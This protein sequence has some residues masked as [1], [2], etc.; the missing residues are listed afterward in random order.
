MNDK[1]FKLKR[2]PAP[3]EYRNSAGRL[4]SLL[5]M[6]Q[7]NQ[8]YYNQIAEWYGEKQDVSPQLKGK[9]YIEFMQ[10]VS[11]VY[12]EFLDDLTDASEIPEESKPVIRKGLSNLSETVYPANPT[13]TP[14]VLHG[15]ERGLLQVAASMLPREDD[16]PQD[17]VDA[18][19]KS[20][21]QLKETIENADVPK[22]VRIALLEVARL[23]RNALDQYNIYGARGFKAAF[24]RMLAELMEISLREG[25]NEVK[26]QKWWQQAV[27]HAKLVDSVAGKMLKYKPLLEPLGTLL[28][29]SGAG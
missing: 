11:D 1:Q 5:E 8:T 16:L 10:V 7:S 26:N 25:P 3:P 2:L 22:S 20:I 12:R 4:L 6:F 15:G 19:E 18:I 13:G 17:D 21:T 14:R 29:G 28:L 24:K 23:S 9:L 27:E